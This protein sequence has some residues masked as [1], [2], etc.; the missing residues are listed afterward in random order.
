MSCA[1]S[2]NLFLIRV[3][4]FSCSAY[5]S[6]RSKCGAGLY[7]IPFILCKYSDELI[8]L[9]LLP[10]RKIV[11]PGSLEVKS[12]FI[13]HPLQKSHHANG[14]GRIHCTVRTLIIKTYVAT[15]NRSIKFTTGFTHTFYC[16]NKLVIHLGDYKDFQ[17]SGNWLHPKVHHRYKL[18]SWRLLQ[19]RSSF[20]Y[21][22]RQKHN[23]YCNLL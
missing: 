2:I 12:H 4:T 5:S 19:Q 7:S 21:M 13:F 14:R 22:D 17:N 6:S 23:G 10:M 16:L 1:D 8:S 18:Y 15:G 11:S 9:V 3:E 20:L